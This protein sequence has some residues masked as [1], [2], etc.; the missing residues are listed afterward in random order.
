MKRQLLLLLLL[1]VA[2]CC[3][4]GEVVQLADAAAKDTFRELAAAESNQ[5]LAK[6]AW[7]AE[8]NRAV[9]SPSSFRRDARAR[10]RLFKAETKLGVAEVMVEKVQREM[11][12]RRQAVT[13]S[14]K[15]VAKV[16]AEQDK[17]VAEIKGRKHSM[18]KVIGGLETTIKDLETGKSTRL[19]HQ[20]VEDL[21]H[22]MRIRNSLEGA[23]LAT[24]HS[25]HLKHKL[26]SLKS[27]N[28]KAK[29]QA[30]ALGTQL[31]QA[32]RV[33]GAKSSAIARLAKLNAGQKKKNK[34]TPE[35]LATIETAQHEVD[36]L[37]ALVEAANPTQLRKD[38]ESV[39]GKVTQY[40]VEIQVANEGL[41]QQ[42]KI[43]ALQNK[44]VLEQKDHSSEAQA[45]TEKVKDLMASRELQQR[46]LRA[47][48]NADALSKQ[49]SPAVAAVIKANN[50]L[51]S[52]G[53]EKDKLVVPDES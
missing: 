52:L 21:A 13:E 16:H 22:E 23:R 10:Q 15:D 1:W 51:E 30:K 36:K 32:T 28:A 48:S 34:S 27:S 50:E 3:G 9:A 12:A 8:F 25:L 26:S 46:T 17:K 38:L 7:K 29:A 35:E 47:L 45:L 14:Q 42:Q 24:L 43:L 6:A 18:L 41:A 40:Q 33:A 20:A 39:K 37:T 44:E 53:L 19:H 4:E 5:A 31:A 11:S 2:S 49:H